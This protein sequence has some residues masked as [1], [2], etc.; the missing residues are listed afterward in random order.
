[1][2]GSKRQ[3]Q[4]E[5]TR[6]NILQTAYRV[7]AAQGFSATTAMIAKEARVS[8]GTIF[9]HFP[10]VN[11]LISQLI[12]AFGSQLTMEMHALAKKNDSIEAL[13]TAYLDILSGHEA[14][15][16]R[17][18]SEKS[19]LP[20]D[21]PFIL[22][23]IQSNIAYHFSIVIAREIAQ[24]T[25]KNIPAAMIFN[26]W[27]GLLHYYLLNKDLFSPDEPLLPRYGSQLTAVFLELIKQ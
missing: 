26:T 23:N 20:E 18:I 3:L 22:A 6:E 16:I 7:Y 9:V 14:F 25:V 13:L 15:Y 21:V 12:T 19:L 4:K 11:D 8:H 17:L 27:M 1:M 5:Q 2:R 10:S 24:R